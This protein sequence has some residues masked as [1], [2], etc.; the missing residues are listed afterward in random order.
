[1]SKRIKILIA[2]I[3]VLVTIISKAHAQ[4]NSEHVSARARVILDN[5]YAGDPDGLFQLVHHLLSPSVEIRGIIGSHLRSGDGF[6]S[7][8][9]TAT[10]AVSNIKEVLQLMGMK[11][12]YAV[13]QGS[14]VALTSAKKPIESVAAK[15][16]VKEAM[17]SDVETPLYVVCG[18]GLTEIAS[19][20]LMEPRISERLTLIWIG[21]SEYADLATSPPGY[22]TL[23]YNTGIDLKAVQV[24]FNQSDIPLWQVPRNAYRQTLMSY[25]EL[26]LRVETQG[27]IGKYLAD[28]I[29]ALM[30]K[31][32][33]YNIRIGETYIMGD[34][35]LVLL[36][37]LQSSFEADPSSSF[38]VMK[39]APNVNDEGLYEVN[40]KGRFIR[41]YNQLDNRLMFSDFYSKLQLYNLK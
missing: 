27:P 11:D 18:G 15:A 41:V 10:H 34:N 31:V 32:E 33:R 36:T 17:R 5:D 22:T 20:Y 21:G 19:A 4:H 13:Y 26:K 25:S 38:F 23:E 3:M 12:K 40:H 35:P 28:K 30:D 37:A 14:N 6:D 7:S 39:Q 8:D 2:G 29:Y 1:M 9:E 16:I 24:I